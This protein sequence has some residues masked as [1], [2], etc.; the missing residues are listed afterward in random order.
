MNVYKSGM[1]FNLG[2]PKLWQSSFHIRCIENPFPALDYIHANPIRK[3]LSV[4]AET[5]PW[6]SAAGK[7]DL[8]E[9][10]CI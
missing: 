9:F 6:S 2:I 1:T 5:Y 4:T 7:W 10:G 3:G 8:S